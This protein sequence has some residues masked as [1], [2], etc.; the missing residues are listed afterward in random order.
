MRGIGTPD[1]CFGIYF[2]FKATVY[3]AAADEQETA[4]CF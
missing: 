1:I 3:F 2:L 4:T